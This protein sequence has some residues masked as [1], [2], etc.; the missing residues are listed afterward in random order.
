MGAIKVLITGSNGLLGQKLVAQ[1]LKNNVVFL[2][3]SLGQNRNPDCA[4]SHYASLDITDSKDIQ[5]ALSKFK[6]THLIHAAAMTNVDA[7]ETNPE[8][9][10]RLNCES[11]KLLSKYCLDF[12]IHLQLLSTDF[13]FDGK[14][15]WYQ[16]T[17]LANPLSIYGK[18]KFEAEQIISN[19]IPSNYSIVRTSIVYGSG[20]GL[21]KSNLILWAMEA[22]EKNEPMTVVDDQF[23]APTWADDL[24]WACLKICALGKTGVYHICGPESHSIYDIVLKI[25]KTLGISSQN[26]QRGSTAAINQAAERPPKTGFNLNKAKEEL[27]YC[28]K[29]I[30]ETIEILMA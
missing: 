24:A 22:L 14:T 12:S 30:E 15:G 3:T 6:P 29:T 2:A 26:V 18:S 7:C 10:Y 9:C 19:T 13:V 1:C 17:D 28:P 23:R 8:L 27:G 11:V 25:S 21:S 20:K 5:S 4:S 16:E